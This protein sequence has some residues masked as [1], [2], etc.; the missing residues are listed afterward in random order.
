MAKKRKTKVRTPE[1]RAGVRQYASSM[2]GAMAA[3]K[4]GGFFPLPPDTDKRNMAVGI[5][6]WS[7]LAME[8]EDRL[9]TQEEDVEERE[10][11][12]ADIDEE[13]AA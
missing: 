4:R 1:F 7:I 3:N 8:I 5:M 11:I 12:Q 2:L 10:S 9:C 6:R 13:E